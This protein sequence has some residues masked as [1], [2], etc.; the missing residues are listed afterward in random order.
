[1]QKKI[2]WSHVGGPTANNF[3]FFNLFF[4][5]IAHLTCFFRCKVDC[6]TKKKYK[7]QKHNKRMEMNNQNMQFQLFYGF[8]HWSISSFILWKEW[9]FFTSRMSQQSSCIFLFFFWLIF[10]GIEHSLL[11]LSILCFLFLLCFLLCFLFFWAFS[12]A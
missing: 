12:F 6:F 8:Y 9:Y 10:F 1:M 7:K 11:V 5:P 2:W 4:C 3:I